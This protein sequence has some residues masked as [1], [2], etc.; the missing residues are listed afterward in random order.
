LAGNFAGNKIPFVSSEPF[1][2]S[3]DQWGTK[4]FQEN[5]M[6]EFAQ[7]ASYDLNTLIMA[8]PFAFLVLFTLVAARFNR[9]PSRVRALDLAPA[10]GL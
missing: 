9:V 8:G 5:A 10:F 7:I 3:S 2:S 4:P 6:T 1:Q